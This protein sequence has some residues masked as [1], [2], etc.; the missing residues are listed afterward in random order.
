MKELLISLGILMTF[1]LG[2]QDISQTLVAEN[3]VHFCKPGVSKQSPGKGLLASYMTYPNFEL[4]PPNTEN[5]SEVSHNERLNFKLKIPC[6]NING[7][8]FLVGFQYMRERYNFSEIEPANYPLF[9]RLNT[10]SLKTARAA[11]YFSKSLDE[12]KYISFRVGTTYSGDYDKFVKIEKRYAIYRAVGLLGIKKS[13]DLEYGFGLLYTQSFRRTIALPFGFY[14]RTFNDK[15]G[16]EFA[17]PVRLLGRYNIKDGSMILFGAE[18]VSRSYSIDVPQPESEV[19]HFRR[20]AIEFSASWQ[21][22]F[23]NWTWMEFKLGYALNR[24]SKIKDVAAGIDSKINP[25][26]GIFGT[27]SFFISPP[28]HLCK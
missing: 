18:Y 7:M 15:W 13:E 27:V 10:V 2:A 22:R 24:N 21:Q 1:S 19:F 25:T 28:A 8:K 12:T 14:N 5:E 17:I 6:I 4:T 20:S 3:N 11:L 16:I 23:T 9:D 26:N